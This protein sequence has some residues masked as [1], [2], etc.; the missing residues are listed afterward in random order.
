MVRNNYARFEDPRS[1]QI[2]GYLCVH[3]CL[4][5]CVRACVRARERA[6]VRVCFCVWVLVRGCMY[7]P[8]FVL[9]YLRV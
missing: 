7:V 8:M 6:C 1:N 3:A 9:A 5:A 2:L 4:R